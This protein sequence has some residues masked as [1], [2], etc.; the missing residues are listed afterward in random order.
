VSVATGERR[1]RNRP[2]NPGQSVVSAGVPPELR[3]EVRRFAAAEGVTVSEV[4][5]RG[6]ELA[7]MAMRAANPPSSSSTTTTA[8]REEG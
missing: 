1:R 4:V 5:R 2:S 7:L 8:R 3:A 6:L